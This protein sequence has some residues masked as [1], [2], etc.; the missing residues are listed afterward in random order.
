[1][2]LGNTDNLSKST[3]FNRYNLYIHIYLIYKVYV[4]WT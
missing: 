2:I 4:L 3:Y 1:M